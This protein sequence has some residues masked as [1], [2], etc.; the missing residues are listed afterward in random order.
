MPLWLW[1]MLLDTFASCHGGCKLFTSLFLVANCGN[2]ALHILALIKKSILAWMSFIRPHWPNQAT[3]RSPGWDTAR[4]GPAHPAG[5]G[6]VS[7]STT[8][9]NNM[10]VI[11]NNNTSNSNNTNTMRVP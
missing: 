1:A 2:T 5:A 8:L 10:Y 3:N 6:S 11:N 4:P 7:N 9:I